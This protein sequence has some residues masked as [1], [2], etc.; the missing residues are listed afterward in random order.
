MIIGRPIA[1]WGV[2]TAVALWCLYAFG[3]LWWHFGTGISGLQITVV[4]ILLTAFGFF[5]VKCSWRWAER[6]DGGRNDD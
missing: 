3:W 1:R 4:V 5:A 6:R 2:A